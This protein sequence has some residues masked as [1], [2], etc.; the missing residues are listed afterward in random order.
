MWHSG[1]LNRP[2]SGRVAI[3]AGWLYLGLN[4]DSNGPCMFTMTVSSGAGK[5]CQNALHGRNAVTDTPTESLAHAD[6][7]TRTLS[8]NVHG[9][10]H[11]SAE[12]G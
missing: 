9:E 5:G 8:G 3:G 2:T 6:P 11:Y 7:I 10:R 1:C 12:H 4:R